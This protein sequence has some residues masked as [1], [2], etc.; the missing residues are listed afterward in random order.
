MVEPFLFTTDI[1]IDD[2]NVY[3]QCFGGAGDS[4]CHVIF[5]Q[6]PVDI[7]VCGISNDYPIVHNKR[8]RRVHR[9]NYFTKSGVCYSD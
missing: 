1:C 9:E 3:G 6:P 5:L 4:D 7:S 8:L 2:R